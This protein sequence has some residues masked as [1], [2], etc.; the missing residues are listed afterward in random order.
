MAPAMCP[1]SG[2]A[3]N[4]RVAGPAHCHDTVAMNDA[5]TP[6]TGSGPPQV[7]AMAAGLSS[8]CPRCGKGA[9]FKGAFSLDVRESCPACGLGFAFVDPGDGPAV[10]AIMILGFL[11]LGAALIVEF[12]LGPPLW[13]HVVVWAPVTLAVA[14]GLLRPL[15]GL[16]IASQYRHKAGHAPEAR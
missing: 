1:R 3:R 2:A 14:F 11:V 8:R 16:L 15:K 9:L 6:D 13:V 12:R 7:S 10:F 5:P 4:G